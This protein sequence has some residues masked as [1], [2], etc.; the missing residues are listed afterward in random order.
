MYRMRTLSRDF[1]RPKGIEA[2]ILADPVAEYYSWDEGDR[3]YAMGFG[4][5]RSKPDFHN[6]F[7]NAESRDKKIE[8]WLD[9]MKRRTEYVAKAKAER[10][11]PH[12]LKVGDVLYSSWGYDQT[13]VDFYEVIKIIGKAMVEVCKIGGR[14][15]H[16]DGPCE[17][18]VPVPG[19]Y[20]DEP[21]KKRATSDNY[22]RIASYATAGP[23][24]GNPVYQTGWGYGH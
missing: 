2:V 17:Y 4:G 6:W 15:D 3:P 24:G 20:I 13:N 21:M 9:S 1:Y 23:W 5:K 22:I 12:T 16:G 19:S 10:N 11:K 7:H 8:E 18:V 14:V